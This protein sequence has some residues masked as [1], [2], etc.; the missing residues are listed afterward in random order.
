MSPPFLDPSPG[1]HST[2][3]P[4]TLVDA[5]MEVATSDHILSRSVGTKVDTSKILAQRR[6]FQ[7]QIIAVTFSILTVLGTIITGYW[8]ARMRK[9]FRHKYVS[10]HHQCP[11]V[12]LL[13]NRLI[14]LLILGDFVKALWYLIFCAYALIHGPVNSNTAFCQGSGFLMQWGTQISGMCPLSAVR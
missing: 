5:F 1:L 7:L 10:N 9:R 8:F 13:S 2:L 14:M 12:D 4:K 3:Q 11:I 6:T